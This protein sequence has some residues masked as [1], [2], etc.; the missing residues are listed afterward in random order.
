[1]RSARWIAGVALMA[2]AAA[3]PASADEVFLKDGGVLSGRV[4]GRTGATVEI[5][6]AAGRVTV[7]AATVERIDEGPSILDEYDDRVAARGRGDRS[8]WLALA[9]WAASH[10]LARQSRQAY[11][12]VV[13]IAPNDP[14]ANR[15]LGKVELDGRWVSLE[16][17]YRA[18]G[19]VPFEGAWVM[20]DEKQRILRDRAERA[21]LER[22]L[23]ASDAR[24]RE[25]EARAREA[26]M[27][28]AEAEAAVRSDQVEGIPLWWVWGP[29]PV[30]WPSGPVVGSSWPSRRCACR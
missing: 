16:E 10:G 17:S 26:E 24:V 25:A 21:Q 8:G 23:V 15:A 20:P 18:R 27:R 5:E 22:V 28:A 3:T 4:L 7:P 30:V 11:E 19:Y 12:H 13:A 29:G 6:V 1:M 14:E 9:R 2:A